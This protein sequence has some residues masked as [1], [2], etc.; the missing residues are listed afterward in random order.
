MTTLKPRLSL[1]TA[2]TLSFFLATLFYGCDFLA[3]K[4]D[5]NKAGSADR[6]ALPVA[7]RTG[8]VTKGAIT[9]IL[10]FTGEL[11]SPL[12][13]DITAKIQGRL[14][15]LALSNGV[16]VT[17][18]VAI[19]S[20]EIL[21]E[22][23]HRNLEAQLALAQAQVQQSIALLNDKTRERRRLEALFEAEVATEQARD[24]AVA[25]HES[26]EAALAQARAQS[27]LAQ[28][29]LDEA[30][31]RAPMDGVVAQRYLDPG[32]MVSPGMPIVRMVQMTPLRLMVSVPAHLLTAL[33]PG[34]TPLVVRTDA[35]PDRTFNCL[36]S[37]IFPTVAQKTRTAQVEI[38]LDNQRN[39]NGN[40]LL[41]PGMY[42]TAEISMAMREG[43]LMIPAA[44]IVRVLQR[45]V[46]FTVQADTVSA[47]SIQTGIRSGDMVEV[48][49]G[50]NE[51]DEFVTMGQN[52]LTDGSVIE[53]VTTADSSTGISDDSG[54]GVTP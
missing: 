13:V 46:I 24:A 44:S 41:L 30:F 15:S 7:V 29:N 11:E 14:E 8:Y 22:I 45:Q 12:S 10:Q 21:A 50:L 16:N 42:A 53:R 27:K 23:D 3:A 9:E 25:A 26:A 5:K 43:A 52:K 2:T 36:V 33:T 47:V 51:G 35:Y 37:R 40:W 28:V 49:E 1:Y 54:W 48:L 38:M 19:S 18:G 4:S 17:E 6:K 34:K 32:S 31:I 20:G 39:G